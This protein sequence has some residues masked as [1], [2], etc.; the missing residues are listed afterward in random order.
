MVEL[1]TVV[2]THTPCDEELEIESAFVLRDL[3]LYTTSIGSEYSSCSFNM[4]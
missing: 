4:H 2:T 1:Y 3:S